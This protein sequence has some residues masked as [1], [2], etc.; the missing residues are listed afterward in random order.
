MVEGLD[1]RGQGLG[2][3]SKVSGLLH[4]LGCAEGLE[5]GKEVLGM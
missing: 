5:Y 3:E 1:S 4:N 2:C